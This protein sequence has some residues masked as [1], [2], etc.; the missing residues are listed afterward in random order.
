LVG[1]HLEAWGKTAICN[2]SGNSVTLELAR[3]LAKQSKKLNRN[4][5][6]AFWDGHEIAEA[7]GSTW[8]VDSNW[9]RLSRYCLAYVNIDNIGISG[10][11][12]PGLTSVPEMK[13][14]LLNLVKEKWG[15]EG[16][17]HK[18]Y[19]GGDES[20]FG[21]GV[22]YVSF[23]TRYT[24]EKLKELNYASLSPWLHSEE[25]T[26][27]KIDQDLY[28]K[29]LHFLS[30]LIIT[31]CNIPVFPYDIALL[32]DELIQALSELNE[33]GRSKSWID[34]DELLEIA[35]EFQTLVIKMDQ[36]RT[37][38]SKKSLNPLLNRTLMKITREL[39]HI[40]HSEAGRYGQD[41]Y[42]YSY[43]GKPIPSLYVPMLKTASLR[44]ESEESNL[45]KAKLMKERNKVSDAIVNCT[46]YIEQAIRL[47]K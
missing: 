9:D 7:A 29:H 17:W 47:L 22:P 8:F 27:D 30:E 44:D 36:Y 37:N 42:G 23:Y 1:G 5:I 16:Q 38:A 34:V 28:E 13:Q 3:V 18:A 40:L 43:V 4:L 35:K 14:F 6:F 25:D 12:E 33:M 45:W 31:L 24:S 46:D 2:S 10:T 15:I 19:K 20:F 32:G 11:S 26:M 39:S 21:V 41:P